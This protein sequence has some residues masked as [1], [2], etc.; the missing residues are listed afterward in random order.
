MSLEQAQSAS[1]RGALSAQ[2]AKNADNDDSNH[3]NTSSTLRTDE[4]KTSETE[5]SKDEENNNLFEKAEEFDQRLENTNIP[6]DDLIVSVT[7]GTEQS[8]VPSSQ[9]GKNAPNSESA[10]RDRQGKNESPQL[11]DYGD[12]YAD[13]PDST[14]QENL[15]NS[16]PPENL[17]IDKESQELI[18]K[19]LAEDLES[20]GQY[21][22]FVPKSTIE[23]KPGPV[24]PVAPPKTLLQET[25]EKK[26]DL[27]LKSKQ[28]EPKDGEK[29]GEMLT[30][31][32]NKFKEKFS[33]MFNKN[34]SKPMSLNQ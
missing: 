26:T 4:T 34:E 8:P 5:Q 12:Y 30:D 33:G 2:N 17:E 1:V 11:I 22:E 13:L 21:N 19:L 16:E 10:L 24:P 28:S 3:D 29:S 9:G 14:K 32:T 23:E 20:Q 7:T 27:Y 31:F 18:D 25:I 6:I 15:M